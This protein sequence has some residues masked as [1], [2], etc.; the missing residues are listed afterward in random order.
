M[1]FEK[2]KRQCILKKERIAMENQKSASYAARAKV[3]AFNAVRWAR[4][5]IGSPAYSRFRFKG[6]L[7]MGVVKCNLF[8]ADAFNKS[9]LGPKPLPG[10]PSKSALLTGLG[11]MRELSARE[12]KRGMALKFNLVQTPRI[13]DI[14][15]DGEHVGIVSG[16]STTISASTLTNTVVE[17]DWGF[18]GNTDRPQPNVKFY[19]YN[20][21]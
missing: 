6:P 11:R 8:V 18:R 7:I 16:K 2:S 1:G 5:M 10:K 17:N 14:C 21:R 13:G 19:R 3:V 4:K 12:F 9:N 15:T 20:G